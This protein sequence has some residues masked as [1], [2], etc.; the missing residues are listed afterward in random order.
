M[1]RNAP[2]KETSKKTAARE[3]RLQVASTKN[4]RLN[5][6]AIL[7]NIGP[8]LGKWYNNTENIGICLKH[9]ISSVSFVTLQ[10]VRKIEN[11]RPTL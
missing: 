3:T 2:P 1:S 4:I 8:I 11:S 10:K 5:I 6:G 7:K 9:I